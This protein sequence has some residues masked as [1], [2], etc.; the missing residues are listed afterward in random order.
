MSEEKPKAS[1]SG[2]CAKDLGNLLEVARQDKVRLI[3]AQFLI[4]WHE[5]GKGS[6][7]RRQDLPAE[8]FVPHSLLDGKAEALEIVAVSCAWCTPEHPDPNGYQLAKI[9]SMLRVFLA[10]RYSADLDGIALYERCKKRG[11][12]FGAGDCAEVGVFWDFL[13]L[14]Q[15]PRT[16]EE[17]ASF[18]S[19]LQTMHAWYGHRLITKWV[20]PGLPQESKRKPYEKSG[21]L[22]FEAEV[23]NL[24]SHVS[25]LLCLSDDIMAIIQQEV[26]EKPQIAPAR[27][28]DVCKTARSSRHTPM[29]PEDFEKL[30]DTLEF[31]VASDRDSVI[32]PQYKQAYGAFIAESSALDFGEFNLPTED[33]ET[34]FA[35]IIPTCHSL[36]HL[37]L[38]GNA[39]GSLKL[40][41]VVDALA[42]CPMQ[43]LDFSTC[44]RLTGDLASLSALPR[45]KQ[46]S[47]G[48]CREVTGSVAVL[49]AM[50]DLTDLD[51][52]A[53][54][55]I[56]GD[57]A[58]L[59]GLQKLC[60]LNLE[61]CV[62]LRGDIAAFSNLMQLT[63]LNLACCSALKGNVKS[64][65]TLSNMQELNL[66]ACTGISGDTH[67]LSQSLSQCKI[68][69]K[70]G[71]DAS[72]KKAGRSSACSVQ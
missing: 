23:A 37:S 24:S 72:K 5:S 68:V 40:Q 36:Q 13:S 43:S 48:H 47:L 6:L 2:S 4:D 9:S 11:Y 57:V 16:A 62:G 15:L 50:T 10:G 54:Q 18:E 52:S 65:A 55:K 14:C 63:K 41:M 39:R 8:A 19:A 31:A 49:S 67:K 44:D 71:G 70:Q 33:L 56:S 3:R 21:W 58:A 27:Y 34:L 51:L 22:R 42:G 25:R 12:L 35:K 61:Y 59:A 66:T 32:K 17:E 20:F 1:Q 38:Q 53:C 29:L 26:K 7:K 28:L 30:V 46:L 45:L 64:L 69:D 60:S